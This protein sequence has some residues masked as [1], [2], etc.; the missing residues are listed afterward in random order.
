MDEN[1]LSEKYTYIKWKET[2]VKWKFR[3]TFERVIS[4]IHYDHFNPE[5]AL[6][7]YSVTWCSNLAFMEKEQLK[8]SG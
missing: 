5:M 7:F 3:E 4:V 8:T 6:T 2:I 1:Y